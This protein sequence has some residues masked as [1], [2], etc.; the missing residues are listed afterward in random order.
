MFPVFPMKWSVVSL[1]ATVMLQ[2][3]SVLVALIPLVLL[4]LDGSSRTVLDRNMA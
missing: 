4:E 2:M 3:F 1:L